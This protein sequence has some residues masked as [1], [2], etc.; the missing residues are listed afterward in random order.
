[1]ELP[2]AI[3]LTLALLGSGPKTASQCAVTDAA[4]RIDHVPIAVANLEVA[5]RTYGDSLGFSFKPGRLHSN[6]LNK[7]HIRFRDGSQLE[8]IA[9][10]WTSDALAEWYEEFVQRGE[11]GAFLALDAGDVDEV[12]ERLKGHGLDVEVTRG[13]AFD[14]ASFPIGHPL[15]HLFFI[16]VHTRA[17]DKAEHLSHRNEAI[18]IRSV[19][20]EVHD[21]AL[22]GAAFRALGAKRC[23]E[24][25]HPAGFRGDAFALRDGIVV[26]VERATGARGS[27]VLAVSVETNGTGRETWYMPGAAHG[28]WLALGG[29]DVEAGWAPDRQNPRSGCDL[30]TQILAEFPSVSLTLSEGEVEDYRTG[31]SGQG[32]RVEMKGSAVAFRESGQ[33][34]IALRERFAAS[35]WTEDYSYAA[36]GPDGSAF[37]FRNGPVLCVFRAHWDGGDDSD[38]TYVPDD[39]YD[40]E[41]DCMKGS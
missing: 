31:R 3:I 6:G 36:D 23:G 37:A 12:A 20:V 39:R 24:S 40:V 27:R 1:M 19:W 18:G 4:V 34:D 26:L 17:P 38:P 10:E 5:K 35:N 14:Y 8:L 11:G 2:A 32:C 16:R 30:A 41:V 29:V 28:L 13:P 9:T 7:L 33:P 22:V 21:S 25:A 15:H